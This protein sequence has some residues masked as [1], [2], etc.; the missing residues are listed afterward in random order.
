[1][2]LA[3][4]TNWN[5]FT[6]VLLNCREASYLINGY[7]IPL[8][9]AFLSHKHATAR[10]NFGNHLGIFHNASL[11]IKHASVKPLNGLK[12]KARERQMTL[13]LVW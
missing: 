5:I 13:G 4:R 1:L 11:A 2:N 9:R 6:G 7:A 10:H 8:V 12:G 3:Q